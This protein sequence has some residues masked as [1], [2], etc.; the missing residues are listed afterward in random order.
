[1]TDKWIYFI[2]NAENLEIIPDNVED[3]GLLSAYEEA[4]QHT[5]TQQELDAYDYA[6]MREEDARAKL[7]FALLK[8]EQRGL[9][10][11][12]EKGLKQGK[13]I[14]KET[15]KEEKEI[16]MIVKLYYKGKKA[17]E[18]SDLL[19]IALEKVEEAIREEEKLSRK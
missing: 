2:K 13:E 8:G 16:E 15:G 11:G 9:E 19:D 7:E 17:E 14:G 12:L 10:R 5:W 6:D 18:I 3:K 1:M 4:N